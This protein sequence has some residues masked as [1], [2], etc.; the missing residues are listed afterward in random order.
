M[1]DDAG[2]GMKLLAFTWAVIVGLLIAEARLSRRHEAELDAR[3][4]IA[5]PGDVYRW[6]AVLYPLSFALMGA[7]GAWRASVVPGWF[8]AG[9]LL[10]AASK[11]LKYWAIRSLGDRWSF[12]VYVVPGAPLVTTGP[13]RRRGTGRRGYDDE[14]AGVRSRDGGRVRCRPVGPHSVRESDSRVDGRRARRPLTTPE[15]P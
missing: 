2:G 6:M 1:R 3:G 5:P 11:A 8:A 12:R 7:E 14:R 10:F 15:R 4:A 9:V 13:Y